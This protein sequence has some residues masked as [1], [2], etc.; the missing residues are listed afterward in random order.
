MPAASL[1][2]GSDLAAQ[3]HRPGRVTQPNPTANRLAGRGEGG[4]GRPRGR[5]WGGWGCCGGAG[6]ER[7]EWAAGRSHCCWTGPGPPRPPQR[8]T[9]H[10]SGG[11]GSEACDAEVVEGGCSSRHVLQMRST[12]YYSPPGF[13]KQRVSL[14]LIVGV[15]P[16]GF[17]FNLLA[18][19]LTMF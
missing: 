9:R 12:E 13:G 19:I 2:R 6:L 3:P 7:C 17:P 1:A 4:G 8:K 18:L 11:S 16:S 14:L 10:H 5:G 15:L